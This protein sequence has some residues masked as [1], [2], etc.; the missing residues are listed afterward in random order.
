MIIKLINKVKAIK[1]IQKVE[2]K[3]IHILTEFCKPLN[4]Q[5]NELQDKPFSHFN[6]E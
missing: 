4:Y 6:T 2:S 5:I 1:K 3:N